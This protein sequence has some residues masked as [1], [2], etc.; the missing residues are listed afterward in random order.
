MSVP[1]L[2]IQQLETE[3]AVHLDELKELEVGWEQSATVQTI[4]RTWV[5]VDEETSDLTDGFVQTHRMVYA[6]VA[7]FGQHAVD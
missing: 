1:G 6:F 3:R 7:D 4:E 5:A 2:R